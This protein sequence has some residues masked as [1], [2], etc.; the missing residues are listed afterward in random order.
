MEWFTLRDGARAGASCCLILL[1]LTSCSSRPEKIAVERPN[2]APVDAVSVGE[3]LELDTEDIKPMY[4][5]MM[6]IDLPSV[7]RVA[8]AQNFDIR[9]AQQAVIA[10]RGSLESAVGAAFPA[11]VPTALFEHTEGT[12]R[13][14]EGNLVGVGFNTFQPSI[15]I[16]WVINP[17]RVIYNI[18]AA[19]KRLSASEHEENAVVVETLRAAVIQFYD[20]VL[21]QA[22]ISAAHEGVLES[23][24]LLRINR[25]RT[26][27]GT[28]V[29]AD[30][31]RAEA[32]LAQRRQDLITEMSAFYEASVALA[33]T[34]H[35]DSSVTL[36]PKL[37][38][39]PPIKLVRDDIEIEELLDIAM[40]FRPDLKGVKELVEVAAAQSGSTWWGAFGPQ[41]SAGYQY[42][43]ITGH[44]N[45][46]IPVVGAGGLRH[47]DQ[48]FSF[49]DQLRGNASAEWKLSLSAFGDLKTAKAFESQAEIDALRLIDRVAAQVVTAAQTSRANAELIGLARQQVVAAAEAL[50]LSQANLEAG[51][52]TTLDVLQAQD[53]VNQA[54][55]RHAAAVVRYNQ[56]QVNLLASL[57]LLG[58][59]T[60][61]PS[62][63]AKSESTQP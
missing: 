21:A 9:A 56:A 38:R 47:D 40:N 62:E 16:Q 59:D 11:L 45:N 24:E 6:A 44:A 37:D 2:V 48:T 10:S 23:E 12:V 55:V 29:L 50:R 3:A 57:G 30:E 49:S 28:G 53:A 31:L 41:F 15:A 22:R 58:V 13:A 14:T 46:I 42:G 1:S 7:V 26:Q 32:R 25:L 52:M 20:I 39:L 36:V 60:L 61:A 18:V 35:L 27:T 17:G 4:T 34:L 19:R 33:V 63:D 54:R 5:E 51:S 43:G 8:A